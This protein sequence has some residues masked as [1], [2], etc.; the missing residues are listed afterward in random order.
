MEGQESLPAFSPELLVRK[1]SNRLAV[2]L[3]PRIVLFHGTNDCSIP[4]TA[5]SVYRKRTLSVLF[6]FLYLQM[7]LGLENKMLEVP[8]NVYGV[9]FCPCFYLGILL[10]KSKN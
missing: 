2:S 9:P 5:R 7:E 4:S 6:S 3:L 10:L 1:P 8:F